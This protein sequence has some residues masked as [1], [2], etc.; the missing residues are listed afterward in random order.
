[1]LTRALNSSVNQITDLGAKF[2]SMIG[3]LN[4]L[5]KSAAREATPDT[6]AEYLPM[7]MRESFTYCAIR[8]CQ[9][10]YD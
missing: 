7:C 5:I 2:N 8:P 10:K 4:R 9:D 6:L 3:I 1:M